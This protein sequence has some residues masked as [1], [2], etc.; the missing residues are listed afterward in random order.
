MPA[1]NEPVMIRV[2]GMASSYKTE[3]LRCLV[4]WA[5]PTQPDRCF[6]FFIGIRYPS[7][8]IG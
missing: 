8:Q 5:T 2:A 4:G 1:M 6:A 3:H 7:L